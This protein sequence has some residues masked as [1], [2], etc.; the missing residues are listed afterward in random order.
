MVF[1]EKEEL[2]LLWPFYLEVLVSKLF[3]ILPGFMVVYFTGLGL[4]MFQ[5]GLL[6]SVWP[7]F[8]LIFDIPTGAVADIYGRKFSVLIGVLLSSI[9][10]LI[11]Y[12]NSNYYVILTVMA[13]VGISFTFVSGANDAWITDL[14]NKKNKNLLHNYFAKSMS[15][16]SIG[17]VISGLVGAY[18]VKNFGINI[19]WLATSISFF[20]SFVI[21]LFGKEY[22]VKKKNVSLKKS[23]SNVVKKTKLSLKYS[24]N[25]KALFLILIAG[26]IM[27]FAGSFSS[28]LTWTPLL[29]NFGYPDYAFGYFIS[30]ISAVGIIAPLLSMKLLKKGQ[31]RRFLLFSFFGVMIFIFGIIFVI[32]IPLAFFMILGLSFFQYISNPVSNVYF[33]KYLPT[34]LR[35]T[36]G[37]I[38]ST[39]ISSIGIISLPLVGLL[40]DLI[41]PKYTIFISGFLMI[42]GIII[43]Y[44]LKKFD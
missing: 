44:K 15:L 23:I 8:S 20:I 27:V 17:F 18:F 13:F 16:A 12:F 7:L 33:Q 42:P 40:V 19:I 9:C 39:F 38:E 32:N 41:G 10:F 43:Y 34:K 22:Y 11:L 4:S 29:K 25:N 14:I 26:I 1:F 2:K 28:T 5:I 6:I 36:I 3:F 35:A 31:E 21:L 30:A 24:Y 37:S